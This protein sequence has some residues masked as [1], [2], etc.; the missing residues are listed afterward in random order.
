MV[1]KRSD[2]D[3][4]VLPANYTMP[5]FRSPDGTTPKWGSRHPI[6]LSTPIGMSWPGWLT[7]SGRFTYVNGHLSATSQ[8]QDRES[9]PAKDRHSTAVP[10]NQ[11]PVNT[12][13]RDCC[14]RQHWKI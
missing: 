3:H 2:M 1:S 14:R 12:L 10:R 6:Y 7:Y 4:T 5:A 9:L 13:P 8:V 11:P